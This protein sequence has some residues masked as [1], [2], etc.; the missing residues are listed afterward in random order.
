MD[1]DELIA[2]LNAVRSS[3]GTISIISTRQN[4]NALLGSMQTLDRVIFAMQMEQEERKENSEQ[5]NQQ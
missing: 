4:M 5:Q 2:Q 3:L 1:K